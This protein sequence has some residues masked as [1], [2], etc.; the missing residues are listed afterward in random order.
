MTNTNQ[1]N[2]PKI[3]KI[4]NKQG[5]VFNNK[6]LILVLLMA[7][8]LVITGCNI[9]S[10]DNDS[11]DNGDTGEVEEDGET[12]DPIDGDSEDKGET[13]PTEPETLAEELGIE[14]IN[15]T[16][17]TLIS[18]PYREEPIYEAEVLG[19]IDAKE[20]VEASGI[21]ANGWIRLETEDTSAYIHQAF[22]SEEEIETMTWGSGEMEEEMVILPNPEDI[23]AIVNKEIALTPDF[24][25]EDLVQPDV[26]W[27][28][29]SN[30]R[31]MRIE[32]AEALED[33]F[34]HASEEGLTLLGRTGFRS[35]EAQENI[36]I[37]FVNNHGYEEAR[38][39]SA[40]P[41]QSEHQ[42]GLA[43]DIT[44][45]SVDGGLSSD[46][47]STEEGKWV[48]ENAHLHGYIIRYPKE[49]EE[50]TGYIYEPWHIRYVGEE[51]A[52]ELYETGLTMEEYFG[53]VQ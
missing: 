43:M 2:T 51:L 48:E 29:V 24:H 37:N 32:A 11:E 38:T 47:G 42:T 17:Y 50:I 3:S 9:D 12:T 49:K 30:Y 31:Y 16:M 26:P 53:Q 33:L 5:K 46:F 35:Y 13:E 15:E 34:D 22:L 19:K 6:I 28:E 8:S 36:F 1:S 41:G 7:L 14:E 25:P 4:M 21:V 20:P 45:D 44:A 10:V 23:E 40:K 27:A 18:V 39:F 52:T